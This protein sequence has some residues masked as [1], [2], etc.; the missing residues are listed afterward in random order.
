[1][2]I[3]VLDLHLKLVILLLDT[4]LDKKSYRFNKQLLVSLSLFATSIF[5][6]TKSKSSYLLPSFYQNKLPIP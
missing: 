1:M 5:R 6:S 2:S 4:G 3:N